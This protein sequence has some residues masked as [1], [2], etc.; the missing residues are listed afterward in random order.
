A[1]SHA[2]E[3]PLIWEVLEASG[4]SYS[5]RLGGRLPTSNTSSFG[6]DLRLRGPD[7]AKVRDPLS[8]WATATIVEPRK[9]GDFQH[10]R[11]EGRIDSGDANR[12]LIIRNTLKRR[13]V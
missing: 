10:L 3:R 7:V 1:V 2:D 13:W 4:T 5:A 12:S 6:A 8:V 9:V 11:I